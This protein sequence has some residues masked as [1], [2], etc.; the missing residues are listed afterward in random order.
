MS[1]QIKNLSVLYRDGNHA[2]QALEDVSL[3]LASGQCIA[4]VGESGSGKTT[5]GMA[6]LGLL[7]ENADM[8]GTFTLNGTLMDTLNESSMNQT[9]WRELAMVFQNGAA[10]LN[11]VHRVIDQVAEPLVQGGFADRREAKTRAGEA[12]IRMGL[13]KEHHASYP[14]QLSGGQAQRVLLAMSLILDPNV[15]IMDEPTA[16]LDA[17]HKAVVSDVIL[18][19]KSTGKAVLLITHDLEFAMHNSDQIAVLYLGQI[20]EIL[21][22]MDLL[23]RPFHPYTLALG[24]SFPS[25]DAVRDLGGIKGDAF[26]RMIH[27]HGHGDKDIYRHSHIQTPKSAHKNGHAPPEGCL[28]HDRCTQAIETC[29]HHPVSLETVGNHEVRCLR[30][31]IA[32]R[33]KLQ[34]VQKTYDNTVALHPTGLLLRCGEILSVVGETGSGKTTLAMIAAGALHPDHGMRIFD[35]QDMDQWIKRDRRSLAHEIGIV[36]QNPAESVSHRF[37]VQEIVAEPLRIHE[38]SLGKT[39]VR[40]RVIQVMEDV[41]LATDEAFL[42]RYPHELNMGAIQRAC[43]AR[44][45]ILN[46]SLLVAD[47]PTSSLDPSVQAK[48]LKL[49]LD[50]QIERGLTM[51]FVTHNIGLARKVSDRI[52]VMLKGRVVEMGPAAQVMKRPAHPYTRLLIDSAT[53]LSRGETV[54]PSE[55]IDLKGCPFVGRCSRQQDIC[56][57]SMPSLRE[58]DHARVA[59]HFPYAFSD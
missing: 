11:P 58:Y 12:L 23:T 3:S 16:S 10:S 29:R 51:L 47:E 39:D 24:R 15:I 1:L 35:D 8:K 25:M 52:V 40:S 17:I 44:A 37:T 13:A 49:L 50:I 45:L 26:Y 34:G 36:Y 43:I 22:A 2:L 38:P 20:M 27:Q 55:S 57:G 14:H 31:G 18:R 21:P 53:G 41:H 59:C 6:C 28:F 30:H 9:R 32:D 54:Q 7:P 46:P 4:L 48:V 33:L 19:A 5:L 42:N 56:K